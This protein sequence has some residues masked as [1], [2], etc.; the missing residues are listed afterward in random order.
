MK[1]FQNNSN[2]L[3]LTMR[4]LVYESNA[5]S[6]NRKRDIMKH[7]YTT[8]QLA[9]RA[10][11]SDRTI[12]YYDEIG[13]LKSAHIAENGYHYYNE[14]DVI[15]IQKI[16]TL[17]YLGFTLEE[18]KLLITEADSKRISETLE[19]QIY[20]LEQKINHMKSLKQALL[21]VQSQWNEESI[22]WDQLHQLIHRNAINDLMKEHYRT[23]NH[24]S[25]RI[26]LHELFSQNSIGWFPWLLSH[27]DFNHVYRLLE[28]GCGNG[29]LW[30]NCQI[31]MR[32]REIFLSDISEGMLES[33]RKA[34][35]E[36]Y[37]YMLIDCQ[38]IPFKQAYFDAVVANHVLFY[39]PHI[40]KAVQEIHR[41]LKS[42]GICYFSA[43]GEHHMIEI[44]DIVK[45]FDERIYLSDQNLSQRFGIENGESILRKYFKEVKFLP[46]E[47]ALEIDEVKPLMEYI[48]SCHG[49][50]NEYLNDRLDEFQAFLD[51]KLLQDERI[52][53]TK[54]VG[55]FVCKGKK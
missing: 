55:M 42:G 48:I 23:A 11:V 30:K 18:I 52:H 32:N 53:V 16:T 29:A 8:G 21:Q 2:K 43:Y 41:V 40:D 26:R 54:E 46:Y 15:K 34:L 9:K 3:K 36:E 5:L 37:S 51:H 47:D 28:V 22:D 19:T 27:I 14:N 38:S 31:D 44:Q 13:L 10:N 24:L 20:L 49:N 7:R 33:A 17:K 45:E 25:I 35:G 39:A 4:I 1:E 6:P 50:Q 12:R